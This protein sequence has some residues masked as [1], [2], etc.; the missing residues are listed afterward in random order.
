MKWNTNARRWNTSPEEKQF[1]TYIKFAT[2]N[3]W[4]AS[5][6]NNNTGP[7]TSNTMT[8]QTQALS[9]SI[10]NSHFTAAQRSNEYVNT[11]VYVRRQN[12]SSGINADSSACYI[13]VQFYPK[14]SPSSMTYYN[15]SNNSV[16]NNG[17]TLYIDEVPKVKVSWTYPSN[18]NRGVISGYKL[19]LY[20]DSSYSNLVKEYTINTTALSGSQEV[21]IKTECKRRSFK[22]CKTNCIL[23]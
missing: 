16:I 1:L 6:N 14:Y 19:R 11:A 23:H 21:N 12:P 8:T 15:S 5:S 18:V 20:S 10:I 22:L 9:Q 13:L 3:S 7:E 17:S 2:D 4:F